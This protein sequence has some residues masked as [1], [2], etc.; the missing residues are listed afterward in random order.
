MRAEAVPKLASF[1]T[2]ESE[3][4]MTVQGALLTGSINLPDADTAFRDA[5]GTLGHRLRRM[6][7]GETGDRFH[8]IIFQADLLGGAD[9]IE[10]VGDEPV[11]L[12][13][14]D[15]RPLRFA[16]GVDPA[17]VVL[18][19]LDYARVASASYQEFTALREQGVIP[20]GIRFQV[21]LPTPLAV[22]IALVRAED[23]AAFEPLYEAALFAELD[24]ILATIPHDDLAIQWDTAV[25]FGLIE[26]ASYDNE[27]GFFSAPFDDL[28]GGLAER[29]RR[30]SAAVPE[31]V[32]LGFHLCYGDAGEKHFVEPTDTAN[33]VR[34]IELLLDA[35]PRPITWL[36]LPVPIERDDDA[37]YAPLGTLTL[38]SGTEL[39]LG[40]VHREDGV[41]GA[42]RRIAAAAK[43]VDDFGVGTECGIGR[44]PDGTVQGILDTHRVAAEW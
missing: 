21:S 20:R 41:E 14:L 38:P 33:L 10:R 31:D 29:A 1:A 36:H 39:Y 4:I 8:W 35:S 15:M 44:A 30:Q 34:Y 27:Y 16:D 12:R 32:E 37:Y 7:D 2:A 9:G 28:W 43:Y 19:K 3:S 40:L 22:V 13:N 11:L 5:V 23:R 6:P 18:P 25:E 26:A 17:S 24:E 42:R